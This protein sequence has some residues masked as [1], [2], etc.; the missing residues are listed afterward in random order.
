MSTHRPEKFK[1]FKTNYMCIK[2]LLIL[3][4]LLKYCINNINNGVF[5]DFGELYFDILLMVSLKLPILYSTSEMCPYPLPKLEKLTSEFI[6]N[7]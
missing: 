6:L 7:Y 2:F 3:L 4:F 1:F 5:C